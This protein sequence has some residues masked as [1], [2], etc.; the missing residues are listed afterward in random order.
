MLKAFRFDEQEHKDIIEFILKFTDSR[1][2]KNESEAIRFLMKKGLD[3][4]NIPIIQPQNIDLDKLKAELFNH[5]TSSV[6]YMKPAEPT[7]IKVYEE[8]SYTLPPENAI[9]KFKL[10]SDEQDP[11]PINP[12]IANM[13]A[14]RKK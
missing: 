7:P 5:I 4:I 12:L 6:S 2:K 11:N 3:A 13:L 1:G 8:H 9:A 10:S 14:N